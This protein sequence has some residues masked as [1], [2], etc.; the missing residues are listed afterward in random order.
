M[1]IKTFQLDNT[2]LTKDK[3]FSYLSGDVVAGATSVGVQSTIGF[4]TNQIILV[5]EIGREKTEI[6]KTSSGSAPGGTS[7]ALN[8]GLAF[9]HPQDTKVYLIDWNQFA[10]SRATAA[11]SQKSTITTVNLQVD[12][13]FSIYND[14]TNLTGYGFIEFYDDINARYSTASDPIPYAGYEDNTVFMIKKRALDAVNEQVDTDLI[15]NEFLNQSLWEARREYHKARGKRPFRRVFSYDLGNVTTGM[16]R[17]AVPSDLERPS[18]AE[19]V[20][21]VRIGV[22]R[23]IDYIDKKDWDF[24]YWQIPHTTLDVAYT[25]A[26]QDV[27]CTDVRDLTDSG[28]VSIEGD[29][30]AYSARGVSGGTLRVSTAGTTSHAVNSDVWQ[31]VSY[32]LPDKFTVFTDATGTSAIYF[33]RPIESSFV[34]Q[35]IWVDYYRTLVP[36]DSDADELDEPEYDFYVNYLSWKIKQRK[37]RGLEQLKDPD[38]QQWQFK[39]NTALANEYLGSDIRIS[40]DISHLL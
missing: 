23:N 14:T 11:T 37:N 7:I 40:P 35:N 26:D 20:F 32:G 6:I 3:K 28:S 2:I 39:K 9:D 36:Y 30:I 33:N 22:Q 1:A 4:T 16:Y 25:T 5:G 15:T 19:N 17:I 38:Y 24:Y 31:N 21:G 27:Y 10:I 12:R 18:T 13:D 8:S 34:N 29:V